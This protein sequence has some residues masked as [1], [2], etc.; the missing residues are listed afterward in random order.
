MSDDAP[1]ADKRF[2]H[3]KDRIASG[4]P[5]LAGAKLDKALAA[6]EVR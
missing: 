6:D 5:K 4:F 2:D 1:K 3:V